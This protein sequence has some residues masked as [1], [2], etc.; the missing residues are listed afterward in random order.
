M[1]L[2]PLLKVAAALVLAQ[3]SCLCANDL[4]ILDDTWSGGNKKIE[5]ISLL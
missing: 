4:V 1:I 3:K 2:L 5:I